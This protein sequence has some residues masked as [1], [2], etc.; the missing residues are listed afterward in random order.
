MRVSDNIKCCRVCGTPLFGCRC[1]LDKLICKEV[2]Q[3]MEG[4]VTIDTK[5]LK[6]NELTHVKETLYAKKTKDNVLELWEC[7]LRIKI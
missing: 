6:E 4:K 2:W 5:K 7:F 3:P 1:Y